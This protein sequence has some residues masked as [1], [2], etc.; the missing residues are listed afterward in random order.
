MAIRAEAL[1]VHDPNGRIRRI[2]EP[3]PPAAPH[4]FLGRTRDGHIWR[5]RYDLPDTLAARLAELAAAEPVNAALPGEALNFEAFQAVLQA[6]AELQEVWQ[7]PAYCFPDPIE[8]PAKVVMIT[9]AN[10]ELLRFGFADLIPQVELRGPCAVVV[11]QGSAVSICFSARLSAQAAEAGVETLAEFR[12][13]G[14]ASVVVAAWATAIRQR[15]RLPLYS[16]S[17]DN[18]ASQGVARRLGLRLYGVDL[19]FS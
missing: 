9:A 8:R 1:F 4:F 14:Y 15:G 17:W 10:A 16:T 11:A 6:Q 3:D 5:C 2:N 12:G 7:G 13:R 19:S 18:L